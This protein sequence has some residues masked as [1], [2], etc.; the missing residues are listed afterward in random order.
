IA[1]PISHFILSYAINGSGDTKTFTSP[2]T[3]GAAN[4]SGPLG[5]NLDG[6]GT[7]YVADNTLGTVEKFSPAGV[8]QSSVTLVSGGTPWSGVVDSQGYLYVTDNTNHEIQMFNSSGSAVTQ[9]GN[10]VL[11]QPGGITLDGA[12]NL[13]VTDITADLVVVFK[14]N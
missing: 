3:F 6:S 14:R 7:V 5:V 1:D 2:A 11:T 12:G 13:Y 9:F 10:P 4:L 8:H